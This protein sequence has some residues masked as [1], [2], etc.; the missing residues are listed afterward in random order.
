MSTINLLFSTHITFP[1]NL[2]IY[3]VEM[4]VSIHHAKLK[5]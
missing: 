4:F 3:V 5:I 1:Y 2:V